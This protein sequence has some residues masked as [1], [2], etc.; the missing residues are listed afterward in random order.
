MATKTIDL[1]AKARVELM[2]R[3]Y[4]LR[5]DVDADYMVSLAQYVDNKISELKQLAPEADTSR[6]ALLVALNLADELFQARNG[7]QAALNDAGMEEIQQKTARLIRMLEEGIV[8][9]K[10]S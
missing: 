6:L 1:A 7:A 5:G 9:G 3:K 8:G 2:G 4:T 10:L